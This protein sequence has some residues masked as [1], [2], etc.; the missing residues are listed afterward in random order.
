M[1]EAIYNAIQNEGGEGFNPITAAFEKSQYTAVTDMQVELHRLEL[2]LDRT[3][4]EL[5]RAENGPLLSDADREVLV[6]KIKAE[7]RTMKDRR[8]ELKDAIRKAGK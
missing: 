6:A 2:A 3:S 7:R 1:N 5:H 4:D 8:S